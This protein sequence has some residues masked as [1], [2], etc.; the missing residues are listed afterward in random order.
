MASK[1]T[2]TF[3]RSNVNVTVY[4]KT[5]KTLETINTSVYDTENKEVALKELKKCYDG[6]YDVLDVEYT[7]ENDT[8]KVSLAT[9]L[10]IDLGTVTVIPEVAHDGVSRETTK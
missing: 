8:I 1:I 3:K 6:V 10:F 9:E 7:G 4:D 5:K 2:R